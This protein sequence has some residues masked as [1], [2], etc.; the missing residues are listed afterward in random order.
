MCVSDFGCA[1]DPVAHHRKMYVTLV[2]CVKGSRLVK[3][4]LCLPLLCPAFLVVV[5]RVAE[6]RNHCSDILAGFLTGAAIA[7]FLVTC[8]VHNFQSRLPSGRRL[9]PWEDL[10]QAPTMES[11]LEKLSVAQSHRTAPAVA[12]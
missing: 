2:F 5:V 8:V 7:T 3:S 12:T 9:S 6:Y 1:P 11:P 10:G 4:L